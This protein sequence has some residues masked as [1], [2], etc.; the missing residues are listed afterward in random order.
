MTINEHNMFNPFKNWGDVGWYCTWL[1]GMEGSQHFVWL[2]VILVN[3]E[4]N[5]KNLTGSDGS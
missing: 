3:K 2:A 5:F 4:I 1:E